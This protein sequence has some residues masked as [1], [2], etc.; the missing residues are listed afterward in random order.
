MSQFPPTNS[1]I[2]IQGPLPRVLPVICV[3]PCLILPLTRLS[4][5][6]SV[7]PPSIVQHPAHQSPWSLQMSNLQILWPPVSVSLT[8]PLLFQ[9]LT[10]RLVTS[11]LP[12]HKMIVLCTLP[13]NLGT[14]GRPSPQ[15]I[16]GPLKSLICSLIV[17]NTNPV[18]MPSTIG[19]ISR[20]LS[21]NLFMIIT[22]LVLLSIALEATTVQIRISLL[23]RQWILGTVTPA[24][25]SISW[26]PPIWV[27]W[28]PRSHR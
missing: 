6:S 13:S 3:L 21:S 24:A 1:R 9:L 10:K 15:V 8:P 5:S 12:N 2:R 11:Q 4:P 20:L 28:L 7:P 17:L 19:I 22:L 14:R 25:M 26:P 16:S 27:A 23:L 18:I